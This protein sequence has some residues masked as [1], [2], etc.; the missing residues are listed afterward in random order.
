MLA[1]QSYDRVPQFQIR[2]PITLEMRDSRKS[3]SILFVFDN[4]NSSLALLH[5]LSV[6]VNASLCSLHSLH[7]CVQMNSENRFVT[8]IKTVPSCF[9]RVC[10]ERAKFLKNLHWSPGLF[11]KSRVAY[12]YLKHAFLKCCLNSY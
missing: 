11:Q 5:R 4:E 9:L 12:H 2:S 3:F 6:N 10:N 7:R 1:R 8:P